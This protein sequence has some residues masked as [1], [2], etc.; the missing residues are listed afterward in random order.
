MKGHFYLQLYVNWKL[1][2]S[3]SVSW[4]ASHSG[5]SFFIIKNEYEYPY[6]IKK[7]IVKA[8]KNKKTMSN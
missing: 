1:L 5:G 4:I 8:Y 6:Y 3:S 2:K 7:Q